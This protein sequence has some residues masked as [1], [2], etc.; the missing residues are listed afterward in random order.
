MF[1][2]IWNMHMAYD[3]LVHIKQ[4]LT[5]LMRYS[6]FRPQIKQGVGYSY[7]PLNREVVAVQNGATRFVLVPIFLICPSKAYVKHD[8]TTYMIPKKK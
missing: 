5:E 4:E 1:N 8:H 6:I 2:G 3:Y 7:P